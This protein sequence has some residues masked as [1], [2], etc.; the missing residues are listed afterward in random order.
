MSQYARSLKPNAQPHELELIFVQ[1]R[2]ESKMTDG[3]II[4]IHEAF[5]SPSEWGNK[6]FSFPIRY[7]DPVL[8]LA[9]ECAGILEGRAALVKKRRSQWAKKEITR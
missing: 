8:A 1:V 2:P 4:P 9:E 6:G 3:R 7:L 5:P